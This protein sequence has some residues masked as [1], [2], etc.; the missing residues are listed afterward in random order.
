MKRIALVLALCFAS[1]ALVGLL[2]FYATPQVTAQAETTS[3]LVR[4]YYPD[5]SYIAQVAAWNEPW[6]LNTEQ[7]YMVLELTP[8]E[9]DHLLELGFQLEEDENLLAL[10]N[11][12][13]EMLPGQ[14]GGIPGYPCYRTVEETYATAQS[15]VATY[16]NLATWTD[17][18]DSWERVAFG[19][20]YDMFFL[21]QTK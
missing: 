13:N 1:L 9:A 5:P 4:A 7:G 17:V 2:T 19:Y 11:T 8:A 10:Y 14:G 21:S 20:W 18:G 6:E 15:I 3:R 12:P 16:P